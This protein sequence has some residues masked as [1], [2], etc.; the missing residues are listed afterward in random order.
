MMRSLARYWAYSS[1]VVRRHFEGCEGSCTYI[2]VG[3]KVQS[4]VAK[5]VLHKTIFAVGR[6]LFR[7]GLKIHTKYDI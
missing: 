6:Y 3:V 1:R 4:G 7:D 5:T 2:E